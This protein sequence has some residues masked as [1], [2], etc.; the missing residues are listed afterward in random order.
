[1][2][3]SFSAD[4][5]ESLTLY[6]MN[7]IPQSMQENPGT[8]PLFKG[9]LSLP[10]LSSNYFSF[11]NSGFAYAD[12]VKKR[13]DDSLVFT[14]DNML[15]KLSASNYFNVSV[16]TDILSFGFRSRKNYFSFSIIGKNDNYINYP[17]D[18]MTLL[19]KGNAT[20]IGSTANF[21]VMHEST[22]YI[23]Y[24]LGFVHQTNN[25]RLSYGGKV[26]FLS[27][28]A[29]MQ[30]NRAEF[31][32]F[33][34]DKTYAIN[35]TSNISINAASLDTGDI[36]KIF[37]PE[38]N[39]LGSNQGL[40]FDV[41]FKYRVTKRLSVSASALDIAST[42][43]WNERVV[44]YNTKPG[45]NTFNFNGFDIKTIFNNNGS[46]QK[47]IDSLSDSAH[48][49]LD[50]IK[51]RKAYTTAI[52]VKLYGSIV[53]QL[54]RN[55]NAGVVVYA[56]QTE[57]DWQMSTAFSV[58]TRLGKTVSTSLSYSFNSYSTNNVGVG[59]ALNPGKL[60]LYA[61][62]DNILPLFDATHAKNSNIR[63]G[64][65]FTFGRIRNP[66]LIA[67]SNEKEAFLDRFNDIQSRKYKLYRAKERKRR[68]AE[69]D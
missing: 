46:L 57:R 55:I 13:A 5:Q 11:S 20:F 51:T 32:L 8:M 6:N 62:S 47:S 60:Q 69:K 44:N 3:L 23:E 50:L 42:I 26:K 34:D 49:L 15:S 19:L 31:S 17:K 61:V 12:L 25:A 43:Q 9:H 67:G 63:F 53:Y 2:L 48:H 36:S 29:N 58:N 28:I 39:L 65:N 10:V 40:G 35:A 64:M 24:A 30:T 56:K 52:P 33:T 16:R 7:T 41:G 66:S 27:G 18:F 4:S 54:T 14:V 38:Q 59:I 37:K 1:M 45:G 21:N 22:A 68:Q